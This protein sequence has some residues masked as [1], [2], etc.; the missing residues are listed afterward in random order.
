[1]QSIIIQHNKEPSI[2]YILRLIKGSDLEYSTLPKDSSFIE[3]TCN[4]AMEDGSVSKHPELYIEASKHIYKLNAKQDKDGNLYLLYEDRKNTYTITKITNKQTPD[5]G[6]KLTQQWTRPLPSVKQ[7]IE[8]NVL[9]D[10]EIVLDINDNL[11][12]IY[13]ECPSGHKVT[14]VNIDD[15]LIHIQCISG[16]GYHLWSTNT[17]K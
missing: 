12:V 4:K 13:K 1:M 9:P 6:Y 16:L 14:K 17:G 15:V 11:L 7:V 3:I 2:V 8:N 5:T 10:P